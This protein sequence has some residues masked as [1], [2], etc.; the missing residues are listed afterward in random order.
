[1]KVGDLIRVDMDSGS[2]EEL[3]GQLGVIVGHSSQTRPSR[4]SQWKVRLM[5]SKL[6]WFDLDE[7]EVVNESR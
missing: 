3:H 1:M 7:L 2:Y 6:F 4:F 5:N